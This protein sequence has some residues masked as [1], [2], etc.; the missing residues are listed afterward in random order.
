[1][2]DSPETVCAIAG[3]AALGVLMYSSQQRH[4]LYPP[5][6]ECSARAAAVDA[7][8]EP[9][10]ISARAATNDSPSDDASTE[11]WDAGF[12]ISDPD[13]FKAWTEKASSAKENASAKGGGVTLLQAPVSTSFPQLGAQVLAAGRSESVRVTPKVA[14]P[15]CMLYMSEAMADAVM[16]SSQE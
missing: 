16:A 1:M 9:A 2:F 6:T 12:F 4:A 14:N 15:E 11:S 3:A 5:A 13:G 10:A 8:D 7:A